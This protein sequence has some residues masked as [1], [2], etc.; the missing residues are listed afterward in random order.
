MCHFVGR[1]LLMFLMV[2]LPAEG[3]AVVRSFVVMESLL[4]WWMC[5]VTWKEKRQ[6]TSL[7]LAK[8]LSHCQTSAAF[9]ASSRGQ[10]TGG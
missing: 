4:G 8:G 1:V 7:K 2:E 6:R 3:F 5:A 9:P 10:V